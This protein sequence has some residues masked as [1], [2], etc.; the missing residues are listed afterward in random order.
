ME[1]RHPFLDLRVLR[2]LL[3]VPT[4]PWSRSKYLFREAM[5][6]KLPDTVRRR[7]KTPLAGDPIREQILRL[8]PPPIRKT[9][10]LEYFVNVSAIDTNTWH[11]PD[12]MYVAAR[13]AAL[14]YWL[15]A[16]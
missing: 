7:P 6:G 3:A 4:V 11:H 8:G 12:S 15:G 14:S 5:R 2:F 10:A 9:P 13:T 1:V 16:F